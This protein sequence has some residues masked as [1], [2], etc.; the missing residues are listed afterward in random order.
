MKA[1]LAYLLKKFPELKP[2]QYVTR[3]YGSS[4]PLVPNRR[5]EPTW[6]PFIPN[7]LLPANRIRKNILPVRT[8]RPG[9]DHG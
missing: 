4:R 2:E 9:Q 1:V 8:L 6:K 3:G 7:I 5:H